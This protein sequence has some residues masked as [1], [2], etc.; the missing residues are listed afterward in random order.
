[1]IY[2]P[3]VYFAFNRPEHTRKSLHALSKNSEAIYSELY[4]FVDGPRNDT[5][6]KKIDKILTIINSYK[7]KFKTCTINQNIKNKGCA[8]QTIDCMN[9]F[10][11]SHETFIFLED[12]NITSPYFLQFMNKSLEI[13][14]DIDEVWSISG[15]VPKLKPMPPTSYFLTHFSSW[16]WASW[17]KYWLNICWDKHKL[18]SELKQKKL[19][20]KFNY[21]NEYNITTFFDLKKDSCTSWSARCAASM[22]LKQ[23]LSFFPKESL[24]Q[25][26]GNDGSGEHFTFTTTKYSTTLSSKDITSFPKKAKESTYIFQ[27]YVDFYK[28][29]K[30]T[31]W[32][33]IKSKTKKIISLIKRLF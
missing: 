18:Y 24:I 25:N 5:D 17:S 19:L 6:Q 22:F 16:G 27:T 33:H 10:C 1:M 23:K 12:D 32:G 9:E 4:V 26:I 31:I 11:K 15:Y 29:H 7:N 20:Y 30:L 2:S 3:I 14:Q 8:Q 21:N 28:S 13:Y